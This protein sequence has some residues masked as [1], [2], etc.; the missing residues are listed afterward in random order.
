MHEL[1][2]GVAGTL[3]WT[4]TGPFRFFPTNLHGMICADAPI[5]ECWFRDFTS[6]TS[7]VRPRDPQVACY[8]VAYVTSKFA[9][10]LARL[11]KSGAISAFLQ[12]LDE[13]F[14]IIGDEEA[15][16]SAVMIADSKPRARNPTPASSVFIDGLY[17]DWCEQPYV[18]GGYGCPLHGYPVDCPERLAVRFVAMSLFIIAK[19]RW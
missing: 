14:S 15:S 13:M 10:R 7:T 8:A 16:L 5:P 19:K 11:G 12:Q 3:I 17:F 2:Q 4:H 1:T 6:S 18:R 9:D